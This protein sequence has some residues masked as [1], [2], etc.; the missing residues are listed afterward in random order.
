MFST[1]TYISYLNGI[2]KIIVYTRIELCSPSVYDGFIHPNCT[3]CTS[4]NGPKLQNVIIVYF[5]TNVPKLQCMIIT[6]L[7]KCKN[8]LHK[9]LK[10]CKIK[11]RINIYTLNNK[12]FQIVKKLYLIQ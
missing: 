6:F 11:I 12:H 8:W 10:Y 7:L 9:Y 3:Q 2:A 5:K 1:N 4:T